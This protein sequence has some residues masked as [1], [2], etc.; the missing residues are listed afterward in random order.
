MPTAVIDQL[1]STSLWVG[2]ES[3]HIERSRED[4]SPFGYRSASLSRV[5]LANL[6]V[7]YVVWSSTYLAI[8]VGVAAMVIM[9]VVGVFR[10]RSQLV[11]S[12][13]K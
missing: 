1:H 2:V 13:G 8:Q 6:A 5:G 3:G 4:L 7:V 12:L 11:R 10:D 9:G